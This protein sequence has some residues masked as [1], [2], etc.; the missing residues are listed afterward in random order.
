MYDF[1][2]NVFWHFSVLLLLL[3]FIIFLSLTENVSK[4]QIILQIIGNLVSDKL[5]KQK[6]AT[7]F[8]FKNS[9]IA[10]SVITMYFSDRSIFTIIK[11]CA[12]NVILKYKYLLQRQQ[13]SYTSK[14]DGNLINFA[15]VHGDLENWGSIS[16]IPNILK[17]V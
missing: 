8:E 14:R 6:P 3:Y 4:N 10:D 17:Q 1:S 11:Y 13:W 15:L 12:H 2:V 9:G 7:A 5:Q 16:Y